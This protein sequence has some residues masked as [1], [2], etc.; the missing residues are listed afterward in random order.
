L[1][2]PFFHQIRRSLL[3]PRP[4]NVPEY[5]IIVII[6]IVIVEIGEVEEEVGWFD[7]VAK[8]HGRAIAAD[9]GESSEQH[10]REK[11]LFYIVRRRQKRES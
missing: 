2:G 8:V 7:V 11:Y 9:R 5:V 6:V 10:D 3:P 1:T 4:D